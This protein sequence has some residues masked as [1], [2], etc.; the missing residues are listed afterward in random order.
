MNTLA[1]YAIALLIPPLAF[2]GIHALDLFKTSKPQM[3]ALC[4]LWGAFAAYPLAALINGELHSLIGYTLVV[5]LAAP[6]IE[7]ML[8]ALVLFYC[9][10]QPSFYYFV[11][12]AIY[13]FGVGIGFATLE[14]LAYVS[15]S[16]SLA[17]AVTRVLSTSLMHAMTS[18]IVGIGLG[19]LRRARAPLL[20]LLTMI[21][22]I[23]VHVIYNNTVN[24]LTGVS[25]LLVAVG[26]GIGGAALIAL[27]I[28]YG[29]RQE[30][31]RFSETLGLANDVSPGERQAIQRLGGASIT[32][33]LHELRQTFGEANVDLIERLLV[34]Q[35]NI[36]ILENNLTSC[37]VSPRL[38]AAW[39]TEIAQRQAESQALRHQLGRSVLSY[40][41]DLFPTQD[42]A[43]WV[44]LQAQFAAHDPT[45][46]HTFD[47]FMRLSGLAYKFAPE[48]LE[49]MALRLSRID[50]F[51]HI[52]LA[53]LENL[54]RA[55]DVEDYADTTLLFDKGDDGD[56]MYLIER[57]AIAIYALDHGRNERHLRTFGVGQVIGD[58]AVLDG[59]HRSAR[60]RAQ[61]DLS[62]MVLRRE[63]FQMF[64]QS[65]PQVILAVLMVLA[66]RAR[67]T[68]GVVETTIQ[69]LGNLARGDSASSIA[70]AAV[71]D[72]ALPVT[73]IAPDVSTLIE[74]ALVR[75]AAR[76]ALRLALVH[77]RD[78]AENAS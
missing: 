70:S 47:M 30:K 31:Q 44:D 76:L 50:I 57:G 56:A 27:Q 38:R 77:S 58:F 52:S 53:D 60:A 2:Y 10:R 17:L 46:V 13:G 33:I 32:A 19:R 49:A 66:E 73:E 41:Q 78:H 18:G 51:R 69:N 65:R 14:N 45:L 1:A 11:D 20:P 22:A 26:I 75:C 8:K 23:S 37:V 7:E 63:V 59:E 21:T 68:T 43:M 54:S 29:L 35:A 6:V 72:A 64:I 40:L 55:V 39:E 5:S 4:A 71:K 3:V 67:Y 24:N 48:Q 61:G 34:T 74:L 62:V 16:P 25:L 28:V 36:G 15:A 12:G 42:S 9:T